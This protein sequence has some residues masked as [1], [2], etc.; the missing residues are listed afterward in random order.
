MDNFFSTVAQ[1]TKLSMESKAALTSRLKEL[2][3]PKGHILV[4]QDTVCNFL[5]FIDQGLTRTYYLKDG[6]EVTDW[7]SDE[8]SFACSIISFINR[9]PDRRII[10]TLEPSVLFSIHHDDLEI[11][12]Y[13]HHDIE[14]FVRQLVSFGLIQLQQKFDDLHFATALQR[15]QTLMATHPTFIQRVP[16]GMIAS[17][18]GVTPETLSRIR[19]QI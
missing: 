9:K 10:E 4:K 8:R 14:N 2:I 15:Y 3:I 19:S 7:I 16:L 17:Y 13:R 1:Y 12:C 11:L 18:L 6:K 5:Y